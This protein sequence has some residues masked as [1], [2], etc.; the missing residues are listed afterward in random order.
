MER[1]RNTCGNPIR[2]F[3]GPGLAFLFGLGLELSPIAS[4]WG[5][6]AAWSVAII[7]GVWV[8]ATAQPKDLH[9][10]LSSPRAAHPYLFGAA[11]GSAA[12]LL[13]FAAYR[14]SV[15]QHEKSYAPEFACFINRIATKEPNLWIGLT[16]LNIGSPSV[17]LGLKLEV[18]PPDGPPVEAIPIP[19]RGLATMRYSQGAETAVLIWN[20]LRR[21]LSGRRIDVGDPCPVI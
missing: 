11:V 17:V 18:E 21:S 7:W 20:D 2:R 5:A 13:I 12:L 4:P 15:L 8:L 9:R 3:A 10:A 1:M 14:F 19:V 16:I 6:F